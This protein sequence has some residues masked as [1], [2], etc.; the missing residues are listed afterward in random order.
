MKTLKGVIAATVTPMN[1]EGQVDFKAVK[2]LT[3]FLIDKKVHGLF[4]CG[5]TGEGIL[6]S[7][8]ERKKVAEVT[9]EEAAG[10]VPV[11]IH[12]GSI[13]VSEAIELTK[14]AQEIGADGAALIP[15]YYYSVDEK[16]ILDYYRTIAKQVSN[17]PLYIYNIP[18]NVK[19]VIT[20]KEVVQLNVDSPNIVGIKDSSMD[21]MNFINFKQTLDKDFCILMGNDAQIYSSI[22]MGGSGAIA[23]TS[24]VFPEIVVEIYEAILA[25][26]LERA[27]KAQNVVTKLRAIFRN[28]PP[29]ASYKKALEYRGI[30]GGVPRR[31]LR[32]LTEEESQ[33]MISEFKALNLL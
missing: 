12:T 28:Y 3:H 20:P 18:V 9:V 10:K 14:H 2:S 33:K 16:A 5:S 30:R 25:K 4:P 24:C 1:E 31:P 27:L 19:N 6:M 21:F 15:P 8:E 11:V 29:V 23:A 7:T 17:F 26:D 32:P 22:L 13:N